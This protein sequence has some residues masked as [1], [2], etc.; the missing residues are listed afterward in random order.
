[1]IHARDD[2][3]HAELLLG[4]QR[5]HEVVLVVAGGRD[6]DV[7]ALEPGLAQRRDFARVGEEPL[8][9]VGGVRAVDHGRVLLDE[10]HLVAGAHE[11]VGD[12]QPDV[13]GARDRDAHQCSPPASMCA[14]NSSVAATSETNTSTSPSWPTMSV[15]D[16]LRLAE[17]GHRREPE[18]VRAG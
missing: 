14:C 2:A 17:A 13:A 4:E 6:H 3:R 10:L 12:E 9:S 15:G 5:D 11:I 7:A 1:M 16:D 8:D 18:A